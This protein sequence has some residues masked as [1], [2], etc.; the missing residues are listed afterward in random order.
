MSMTLSDR[1]KKARGK[2]VTQSD[3]RTDL[4]N[5]FIIVDHAMNSELILRCICSSA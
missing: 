3:F 2:Y 1:E 4:V 5:G